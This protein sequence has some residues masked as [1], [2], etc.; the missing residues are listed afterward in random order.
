VKH[1]ETEKGWESVRQ[2]AQEEGLMQASVVFDWGRTSNRG[3]VM[4]QG[5]TRDR[6]EVVTVLFNKRRVYTGGFLQVRQGF[7]GVR[8]RVQG[9]QVTSCGR[10]GGS[11]YTSGVRG[12]CAVVSE[13]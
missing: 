11:C 5:R 3:E 13:Q 8:R 7:C 4:E 2:R 1:R 6:V 12:L 10:S 9:L